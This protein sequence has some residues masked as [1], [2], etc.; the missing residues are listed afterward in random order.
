MR[1]PTVIRLLQ[2]T[3]RSAATSF[4]GCW[5]GSSPSHRPPSAPGAPT[6]S[7]NS[8][9]SAT[10]RSHRHVAVCRLAGAWE[11]CA[12]PA[13]LGKQSPLLRDVHEDVLKPDA[14]ERTHREWRRERRRRFQP[15]DNVP[16]RPGVPRVRVPA[17]RPRSRLQRVR[18]QA[19]PRRYARADDP[20]RAARRARHR[21]PS[22]RIVTAGELLLF[23]RLV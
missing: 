20:S 21:D 19:L 18:R 5:F 8:T 15:R 11:S 12:P 17:S 23:K 2:D 10:L 1:Q 6:V 13:E 22:R 4:D 7:R 14:P 3:D 9:S 16:A